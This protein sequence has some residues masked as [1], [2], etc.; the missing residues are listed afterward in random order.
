MPRAGD[1]GKPMIKPRIHLGV[2]RCD[3]ERMALV[4]EQAKVTVVRRLAG[5]PLDFDLQFAA[6]KG[7]SLHEPDAVDQEGSLVLVLGKY[8]AGVGRCIGAVWVVDS[9]ENGSDLPSSI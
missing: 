9:A 4:V 2:I 1:L 5:K 8:R 6:Q 3:N 7:E